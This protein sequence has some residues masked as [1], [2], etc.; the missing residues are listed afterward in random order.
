MSEDEEDD[1]S[2]HRADFYQFFYFCLHE[3]PMIAV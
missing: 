1:D 2:Q 3:F